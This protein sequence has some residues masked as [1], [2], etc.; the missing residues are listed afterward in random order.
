MDL[1][2][3]QIFLPQ[4]DIKDISGNG[5][6]SMHLSGDISDPKIDGKILLNSVSFSSNAYL[7]EKVG[8]FNAEI[9]INE[10]IIEL[11]PTIVSIGTGNISVAATASLARWA[12]GDIKPLCD[13]R[14]CFCKI[15]GNHCWFDSQRH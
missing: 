8:P 9:T 15:Q 10:G 14:N 1:S 4:E 3:L 5:S 2:L 12:I 13:W 11:S 6:A 7:L